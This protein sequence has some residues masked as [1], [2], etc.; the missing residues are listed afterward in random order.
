MHFPPNRIWIF[1]IFN[2]NVLPISQTRYNF[3]FVFLLVF[4]R[5]CEKISETNGFRSDQTKL[6]QISANWTSFSCFDRS[7][8]SWNAQLRFEF[9]MIVDCWFLVNAVW[10][11]VSIMME[12]ADSV[13][14]LYTRMRLWE[15]PEQYVIEPTDGSSGSSLAVSRVD[16][17]MK[18]I[19]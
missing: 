9:F 11:G 16:G 5:K 15:F 1:K 10:G 3:P 7:V 8:K 19:G 6:D 4:P 18:L 12:K 2:V 14:K 17:S 13:Q